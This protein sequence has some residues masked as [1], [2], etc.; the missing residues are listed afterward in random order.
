MRNRKSVSGRCLQGSFVECDVVTAWE[1]YVKIH[2]FPY[3]GWYEPGFRS[4]P[5]AFQN[6]FRVTSAPEHIGLKHQS[7]MQWDTYGSFP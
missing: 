1:G 3:H 6:L 5:T 2:G 4:I 7:T